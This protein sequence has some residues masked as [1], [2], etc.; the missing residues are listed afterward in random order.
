[1]IGPIRML[2]SRVAVGVAIAALCAAETTAVAQESNYATPAIDYNLFREGE[3]R[4]LKGDFKDWTATCDEVPRIKRRFCSLFAQGKNEAGQA[5]LHVTVSTSDDG[6]PAAMIRLPFGVRLKNSI[7]VRAVPAGKAKQ[8]PEPETRLSVVNCDP[9][10]CMTL[11][12]LTQ[13]QLVALNTGGEIRIRYSMPKQSFSWPIAPPRQND[14]VIEAIIKGDGFH[15]A[16]L[17][18]QK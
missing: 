8:R 5:L 7:E 3:V 4:R 15:D 17:A 16:I 6:R 2:R 12:S 14:A 18:T 1:M 9:Q 10:S 11:W 13:G